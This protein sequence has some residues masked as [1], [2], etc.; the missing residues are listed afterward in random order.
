MRRLAA[1]LGYSALMGR[2]EEDAHR[3]VGCEIHRL[4]RDIERA[5]GRGFTFAGDGVMAEFPSD[6]MSLP[7]GRS[8]D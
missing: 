5:D 8:N 7:T 4:Y 6:V 1:I 2:A 3:R